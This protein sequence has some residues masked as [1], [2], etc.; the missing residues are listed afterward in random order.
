MRRLA[1]ASILLILVNFLG[2]GHILAQEPHLVKD[3]LPGSGDGD[4]MFLTTM[5]G[6]VFFRCDDGIHGFELWKS[7]GTEQG[8]V[9]V[10]DINPGSE[11]SD[12]NELFAVPGTLY[13]TADDGEHVWELW[14]TDGTEAGTI[15]VL[16][17]NP[18]SGDSYPRDFQRIG[19]KLLFTAVD[20]SHGRELWALGA[21]ELTSSTYL[22][23]ILRSALERLG[24][25]SPA[26]RAD[27]RLSVWG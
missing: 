9:M 25:R 12:P 22:P 20:G 17:I 23:L 24:R 26:R 13:F 11:H 4:P 7:D 2:Y 14:K 5:G 3:I 1:G 16:D 18:G 19:D 21:S 6:L 8:P 15:M 10:K 27:V